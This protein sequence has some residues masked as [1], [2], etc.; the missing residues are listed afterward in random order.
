MLFT[1]A[2]FLILLLMFIS[3]L[4]FILVLSPLSPFSINIS[5]RWMLQSSSIADSPREFTNP[6]M[7]HGEHPFVVVAGHRKSIYLHFV[8]DS[9]SWATSG[10]AESRPPHVGNHPLRWDLI[11]LR[12]RRASTNTSSSLTFVGSSENVGRDPRPSPARSRH[13]QT[14][15]SLDRILVSLIRTVW[16]IRECW[17]RSLK[18]DRLHDFGEI[19]LRVGEISEASVIWN[20]FQRSMARSSSRGI[21]LEA[22]ILRFCNLANA[23]LG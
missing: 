1:S 18:L 16:T 17:F 14:P 11:M 13:Y 21:A 12:H 23:Y 20:R 15:I 19:E 5:R 3:I 10:P 4:I 6:E 9:E 7:I 2:P 8:G 22:R